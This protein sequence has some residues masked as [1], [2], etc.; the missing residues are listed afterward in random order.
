MEQ[1]LELLRREI[2]LRHAAVVAAR[3]AL[4]EALGERMCGEGNGPSAADVN[5]YELARKAEAD[6]RAQLERYLVTRSQ[7][8]IEQARCMAP[9]RR[10]RSRERPVRGRSN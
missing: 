5:K 3:E 8:L 9:E 4:I 10:T 1:Q 2:A 6:A 7:E